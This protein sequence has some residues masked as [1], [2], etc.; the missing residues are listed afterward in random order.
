MCIRDSKWVA[1]ARKKEEEDDKAKPKIPAL[2][3]G[4]PIGSL[5]DIWDIIETGGDIGVG[6]VENVLNRVTNLLPTAPVLDMVRMGLALAIFAGVLATIGAVLQ[7]AT[8]SAMSGSTNTPTNLVAANTAMAS[9]EG[10][11]GGAANMALISIAF[12]NTAVINPLANQYYMV[13]SHFAHANF[14]GTPTYSGPVP[15]G[16]S[17]TP[18]GPLPT[19]ASFALVALAPEHPNEVEDQIAT[20]TALNA[21]LADGPDGYN[22][23]AEYGEE[24]AL[25]PSDST[26]TPPNPE[27][28]YEEDVQEF[29]QE[30]L[31]NDYND[32]NYNEYNDLNNG[33]AIEVEDSPDGERGAEAQLD[34]AARAAATTGAATAATAFQESL[35]FQKGL[36]DAIDAHLGDWVMPFL[37]GMAN[38][39]GVAA[40]GTGLSADVQVVG[41]IIQG[42]FRR[43]EVQLLIEYTKQIFPGYANVRRGYTRSGVAF[44]PTTN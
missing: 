39:W 37:R 20:I 32:Y 6:V 13:A 5:W 22:A 26:L 8:Q 11:F 30:D 42:I 9:I 40:A 18:S 16:L 2:P 36:S 21:A 23:A 7:S 1:V 38:P 15:S 29:A 12:E 19:F 25:V 43:R 44:R 14:L 35:S 3:L 34:A 10:V 24:K 33:Q 28:K 27:N 4:V 31:D 41:R 17:G